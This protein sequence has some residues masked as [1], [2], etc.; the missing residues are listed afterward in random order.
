MTI[1]TIERICDLSATLAP[2]CNHKERGFHVKCRSDTCAVKFRANTA[3]LHLKCGIHYGPRAS[4]SLAG[5][6]HCANR[7]VYL[8]HIK[9]TCKPDGRKTFTISR[10]HL[11][12]IMGALEPYRVQGLCTQRQPLSSEGRAR[13]YLYTGSL[14]NSESSFHRIYTTKWLGFS[15]GAQILV[16]RWLPKLL[17]RTL[18]RH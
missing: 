18:L 17:Q 9:S 14:C 8:S 11:T 4:R 2:A 7:L 16:I 6:M 13:T 15:S 5:D 3:K 10:N 12:A 1:I